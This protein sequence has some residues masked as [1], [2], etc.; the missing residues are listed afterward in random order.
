MREHCT[1]LNSLSSCSN[2]A[3]VRV[4]KFHIRYLPT[5][6]LEFASPCGNRLFADIS[7]S[8]GVSA[9]FAETTT[10]LAF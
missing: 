3:C 7:N 2:V 9:P 8:R 10:A 4:V 1:L 5:R 6:P